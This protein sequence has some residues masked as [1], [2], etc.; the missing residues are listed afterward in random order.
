MTTWANQSRNSSSYSNSSKNSSSYTNQ[1]KNT[2][3]IG[4]ILQESGFKLLQETGSG[5]LQEDAGQG[6]RWNN[7]SKS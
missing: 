6:F 1:N 5:L 7:Q 3:L 4:Y 2:V